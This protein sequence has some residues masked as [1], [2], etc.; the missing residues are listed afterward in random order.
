MR[1]KEITIRDLQKI[2]ESEQHTTTTQL[3]AELNELKSKLSSHIGNGYKKFYVWPESSHKLRYKNSNGRC[4]FY[5]IVGPA[6][7][8]GED[9]PLLPYQQLLWRML[10]ER[11]RLW[12]KKARGIGLSTLM[13]YII[14]YKII[15]EFKPGDRVVIITGIRIET[16]AD[17]IRRLKLLFQRNFPGIYAE[18]IKQKDTICV[19]NNIIVEGYPAGHT[20][21]VRGLDR[22]KMIWV[23]E[24]DWFA[25]AES[26]GVRS[27]IEAFISK[28]NS[29]NMYLVLSSTA[30]K[31]NGLFE[32]IEKED[33][34]IYFKMF[35]LF[36]YGLEGPKP[37]YDLEFIEEA[38]RSLHDFAREYQ[39]RYLGVT[40]NVIDGVDVDRCIAEGDRL[41]KTAP[42]DNWNIETKYVLSIDI[43]WGSS[44]TAILMSRF[45]SG[46]V[47]IIYSREYSR[48][49]F[50]DIINEIW[51][52]KNKCNDNLQ[53]ILMDASA[54][55]LYT[56]LCNNF[57]QNPSLKY[58]KEKQEWCK[59][60]N[61]YLEDHLFVTP[62]PFNPQ[63]KYMLNHTQRMM[64][65][66]E[67]DGSAM[68][69]LHS[70]FGDLITACRSAYVENE[71]L[72]KERGAFADSFDALLMNLSFY[73]WST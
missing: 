46:K 48:P 23:D 53:N 38:K 63:A 28:P 34:S 44:N 66:T 12:I 26:R 62:I 11:R 40:G 8:K 49:V 55:E 30:N 43:G 61:G 2:I 24:A 47:Q 65:E 1:V 20:D 58:L 45:I 4:C 57:N 3:D 60:T 50:Q 21:S 31:P 51:R 56:T 17:L 5:H 32:T 15:T 13:L 29:E 41:A 25:P 9:M 72:N 36:E 35:I 68:V 22:V 19:L 73:R 64:Q 37:I 54:T 39:G 52:L 42:L 70:S 7:K 27:A 16:V 10:H 67:D 14:A 59:K 33:P 18:L 69:G 6:Q 71:R